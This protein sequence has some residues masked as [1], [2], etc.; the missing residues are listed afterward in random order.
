MTPEEKKAKKKE[1]DRLRSIKNKE[2]NKEYYEK[3]KEYIQERKA[4]YFK[5]KNQDPQFKEQRAEYQQ[6]YRQ[7]PNGKKIG[8]INNW[9]G[10]GVIHEDFDKLY[11][12]YINTKECNVCHKVFKSTTDRHLDHSHI[13]GEYRNVLCRACNT[14]DYWVNKA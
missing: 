13:T 1:Y 12:L 7:T 2:L 6:E 11:S 14:R 9:K 10:K 8:C 3:N 4:K 5:K